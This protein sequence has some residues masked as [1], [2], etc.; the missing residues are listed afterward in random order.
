MQDLSLGL[1]GLGSVGRHY[2]A[3]LLKANGRLLVFDLDAAWTRSAESEG[4]TSA[5][6]AR[7][8]AAQVDVLVL[9]LPSPT[10]VQAVMLGSDGVLAG[11]R[12]GLLVADA[13]TIDPETCKRLYAA[14]RDH[15]I[16]YLECPISGGQPGG[17]GTEGARAANVTFMVGGDADAFERAR[18]VLALLGQKLFYLGPAGSGSTV[19]LISNLMAGLHMLVAAEA[20]TLGAAAGFAPETL[21]EVF[22]ETDAKSYTFTDY[23]ATRIARRDF[24]PGFAVDLMYKDHRLASELAQR[25]GVPLLLNEVALQV[26]QMLRA[27]G[28]GRKDHAEVLNFWGRLAGLDVFEPLQPAD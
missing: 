20:L 9:S 24:E 21:V 23:L 1:I 11:G 6:S 22:R 12:P 3:H 8:L 2:V 27:Q 13:S 19:K 10:A 17:A 4:A 18:P 16:D 14:A 26:N 7:E 28:L 25:L 5:G 15:G